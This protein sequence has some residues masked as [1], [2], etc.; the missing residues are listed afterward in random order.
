VAREA[1]RSQNDRIRTGGRTVAA[2]LRQLKRALLI[3]GILTNVGW[4]SLRKTE[5]RGIRT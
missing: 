2:G 5:H 4:C 3:S 1:R